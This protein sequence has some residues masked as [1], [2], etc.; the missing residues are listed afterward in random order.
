MLRRPPELRYHIVKN[1]YLTILRN[2]T[3]RGYL[4]NL[5][6][7]LAR[8]VAVAAAL[9]LTSP[10]VL[11]RLLGSRSLFAAALEKRR[12]DRKRVRHQV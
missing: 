4:A 3:R 12:L 9:L 8:D 1:R 5:P 10:G 2:D 7:V 6:F 11:L